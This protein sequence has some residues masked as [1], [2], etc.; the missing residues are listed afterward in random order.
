M[1]EAE[2][3][4]ITGEN[5]ITIGIIVIVIGIFLL[6]LGSALLSTGSGDTGQKVRGGGVIMIGPIPIIFG[7]D[8]SSIIWGVAL[9]IIL[10]FVSYLLF[11]RK[12][13]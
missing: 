13:T 1:K 11:Y 9:A 4:M 10:M 12:W 6:F 2:N 7:N 3:I 5:L 8:R